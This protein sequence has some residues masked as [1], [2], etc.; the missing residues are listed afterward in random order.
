[1][2]LDFFFLL[3]FLCF[4]KFMCFEIPNPNIDIF[5]YI[6]NFISLKRE[7]SLLLS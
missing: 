1:M 6:L 7:F 3:E 2:F 4:L 5:S